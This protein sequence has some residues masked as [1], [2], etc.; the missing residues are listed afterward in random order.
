MTIQEALTAID[1]R[2]PN[3]YGITDKLAWLSSLDG[4]IRAEIIDT[5]EGGPNTDFAPYTIDDKNFL[6]L[7]PPPY[8]QMYISWL[9]SRINYANAEYGRYNNAIAIFQGEYEDYRNW[10]N[11]NHMPI[12]S[13]FSYF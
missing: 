10:Y 13:S 4:Q 3:A 1:N 11:R 2:S 12:G 9:E 6:L 5:H 8:D 7:A